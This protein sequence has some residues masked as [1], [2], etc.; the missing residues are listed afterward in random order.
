M[1][2]G[3]NGQKLKYVGIFHAQ[4]GINRLLKKS[5]LKK[6]RISTLWKSGLLNSTLYK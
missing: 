3:S 6:P 5:E 2:H 4:S 1:C